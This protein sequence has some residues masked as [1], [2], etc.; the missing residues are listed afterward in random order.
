MGGSE[1]GYPES[2]RTDDAQ[3][4]NTI[5][6]TFADAHAA[7]RAADR[8][9][10]AGFGPDRIDVGRDTD[11]KQVGAAEQVEERDHIV[12]SPGPVPVATESMVK[13]GGLGIVSGGLLFAVAGLV[14]GFVLVAM[15]VL[16]DPAMVGVTT[17]AAGLFGAVAGMVIGAGKKAAEDKDEAL[18]AAGQTPVG[19]SAPTAEE[20]ER[21]ET[22]LREAGAERIDHFDGRQA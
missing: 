6:A 16:D 9:R 15:G 19:V 14:I 3:Q 17:L 2:M 8:L 7:K 1:A 11:S 22:I 18:H 5:V 4:P 21:A 10:E 12:M 20:L 13:G